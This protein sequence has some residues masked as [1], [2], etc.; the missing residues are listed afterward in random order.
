MAKSVFES[1]PVQG[2][3]CKGQ[4]PKCVTYHG[5]AC[6]KALLED[7]Y[8]ECLH[9]EDGIEEPVIFLNVYKEYNDTVASQR[10]FKLLYQFISCS[11][12]KNTFEYEHWYMQL[13]YGVE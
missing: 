10:G 12:G 3:G 9:E 8:D 4:K 5:Y 6:N 11:E 1:G 2:V 13:P 7:N